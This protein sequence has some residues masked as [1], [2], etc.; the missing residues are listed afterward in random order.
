MTDLEQKFFDAYRITQHQGVIEQLRARGVP[1]AD[2]EAT[3][4][5]IIANAARRH[6]A[7]LRERLPRDMCTAYL[8]R[9]HWLP[10]PCPLSELGAAVKTVSAKRAGELMAQMTVE[11]IAA[12]LQGMR[13]ML[14]CEG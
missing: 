12:E 8:D 9:R 2:L 4:D 10:V 6:A 3:A 1:A 13:L 11:D 7:D 14:T 5:R